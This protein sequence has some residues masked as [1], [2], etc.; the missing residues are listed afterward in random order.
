M[1]RGSHM[2][3]HPHQV[4]LSVPDAVA[5]SSLSRSL[6]YRLMAD[7]RLKARKVGSRTLLSRAEIDALIETGT[8][9]AGRGDAAATP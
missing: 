7:G 9:P 1:D 4:W 8:A 2:Q 3:A 5:H 6:L